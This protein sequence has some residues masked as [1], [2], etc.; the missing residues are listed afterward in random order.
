MRVAIH[1]VGRMK[2][3]PETELL[4]R[5]LDRIA[6]AGR[7]IGVA[8]EPVREI[9]ES[10][11]ATPAARCAEESALVLSAIGPGSV[12]IAMDERG[13]D[14]PSTGLAAMLRAN[15]NGGTALMA[16]C[17][18]GPDGHGEEMRMRAGRVLRFGSQT[19][20]HQLVR[21][22]LAEQ[23]YRAVTILGGHPYHRQ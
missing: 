9:A 14:I 18:G 5:Y 22:M 13:E 6:K 12:I 20:P 21:V 17:I 15:L 2:A 11:A 7:Q 3:G 19:W 1:A 23:L 4:S 8:G 16:F 10:R